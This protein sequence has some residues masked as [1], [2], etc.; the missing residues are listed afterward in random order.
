MNTIQSPKKPDHHPPRQG[1]LQE[2]QPPF[3]TLSV[4]T[5]MRP[6]LFSKPPPIYPFDARHSSEAADRPA[7]IGEEQARR[8]NKP[9][10]PTHTVKSVRSPTQIYRRHENS[11]GGR[12]PF[13]SHSSRSFQCI[14]S[15]I[16]NTPC[17]AC[18]LFAP[19]TGFEPVTN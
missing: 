10:T 5:K 11:K 18:F 6:F 8:E 12:C 2:N 13:F 3:R 1:C 9:L 15:T 17:W 19:A 7:R 16:K 14:P 4:T